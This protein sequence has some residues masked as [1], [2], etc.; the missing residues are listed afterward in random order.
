MNNSLDNDTKTEIYITIDTEFSIAGHFDDPEKYAPLAEPVVSCKVN[1]E[2]NGLGYILKIFEK[3][4]VKGT[5]F[6][7]CANYYYFGDSPMKKIVEQINASG[8]D[9]QLH[10]HPVWLSFNKNPGVVTFPRNDDCTGRSYDE[11]KAGVTAC[12]EIF[13]KWV[14]RRPMAVRTGS[15]RVDE[16]VYKVLYDLGVPMASNIALGIYMPDSRNLHHFSGRHIIDGVH[17]IS[18]FSYEDTNFGIAKNIKSL[19]ITSCS[20]PEMK[21]L[22]IKARELGITNIVILTHPFEFVKKS[23]FQYTRLRKNRVN[24]NR[25]ENLCEFVKANNRDFE[26][27]TFTDLYEERVPEELD[28]PLLSIPFYYR[29]GRKLHNKINDLIWYY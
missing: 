27:K 4:S 26:F 2:D 3:Y 14:G 28:Q 9:I 21:Y 20:W 15:L 13:Q 19:Q 23:D 17:E 22:L 25:L 5:F 10:I 24:Q 16:N 18:V 7:E 12:I 8:H 11:L 6:V 1:G 29:L